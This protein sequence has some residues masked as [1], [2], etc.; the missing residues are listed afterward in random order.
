MKKINFFRS[1]NSF[2]ILFFILLILSNCQ[3]DKTEGDLINP[4]EINEQEPGKASDTEYFNWETVDWMPQPP[5][6]TPINIPWTGAGSLYGIVPADVLADRKAFDGWVLVYSTFSSTS[7]QPNPYFILYNKFR[8]LMRIFIYINNITFAESTYLLDGLFIDNDYYNY[9]TLNY[10]S[11]E[12][13]DL[14][15]NKAQVDKVQPK[16]FNG[17]PLANN[18]WY[19]LQYEL[20]YDPAIVPTTSENP[21]QL[22]FYISSVNVQHISLGGTLQGTIEGPLGVSKSSTGAN[23]WQA[24]VPG[25]KS[26]GTGALSAFGASFLKN[27]TINETTGENKLGLANNVF[28]KVREG[29]EGALSSSTSNIPGAI[30]NVLSAI[31]GGST[32]SKTASYTINGQIKLDGSFTGTGALAS[33][34]ISFYMPGSIAKNASGNYNVTGSIPLYNKPLGLF[35]LSKKPVIKINNRGYMSGPGQ[36]IYENSYSIDKNSYSILWNPELTANA[37]IQRLTTEIIVMN[38]SDCKNYLITKIGKEET[39][40]GIYSWVGSNGSNVFSCYRR[41]DTQPQP[42]YRDILLRISF[43]VHPNNGAPDV[44]VVKTFAV[45]KNITNNFYY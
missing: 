15:T 23:V 41:P 14:A 20:A 31:I 4:I 2:F 22:A 32:S 9:K 6:H 19:F 11:Q 28:K 18:K 29:I 36:Y 3:L 26:L 40:Q 45:T 13:I 16:P 38:Y 27:K 34:S 44:A 24:A 7:V 5:G 12:I 39:I 37:A 33:G 1:H 30:V 8:G 43:V 21:P 35:S 10:E 25:L 42:V 17:P